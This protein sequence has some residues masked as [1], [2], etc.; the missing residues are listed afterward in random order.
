MG[1][2]QRLGFSLY[3]QLYYSYQYSDYTGVARH[4]SRNLAGLNFVYQISDRWSANVTTYLVDND[5]S[6]ARAT[7][8]TFGIGIGTIY[9]F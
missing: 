6:L 8:Q 4:D 1:V 2:T 5:S 3:A 7:Y 9:R